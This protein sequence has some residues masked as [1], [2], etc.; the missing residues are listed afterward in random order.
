MIRPQVNDEHSVQ[1]S[2][3]V[4][5]F[6]WCQYAR[7]HTSCRKSLLSNY[8]PSSYLSSLLPNPSLPFF[9]Y[10]LL[11][12]SS[13][14][15]SLLPSFS[16]LSCFVSLSPFFPHPLLPLISCLSFPTLLFSFNSSREIF[17]S[18]LFLSKHTCSMFASIPSF[19]FSLCLLSLAACHCMQGRAF[20]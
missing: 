3:F 6:C 4:L 2:M 15:S 18:F 13:F 14:L 19:I 20:L 1:P 7:T 12:S 5:F 17:F 8:I 16:F 10:P 9:L 11:S